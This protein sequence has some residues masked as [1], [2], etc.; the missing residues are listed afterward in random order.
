VIDNVRPTA[1]VVDLVRLQRNFQAIRSEVQASTGILCAVKGDAYGHGAVMCARSLELA[2]ADWFGVALVEEG[3]TLRRAGVSRPIL[4]L[5]GVGPAGAEAAIHHRL[6][7]MISDLG[8]AERINAAAA[9]R[10]EPYGVHLKV[11]TGMGRLGVPLPHWGHFLDRIADLKWLRVDGIASH[12]A[13]SECAPGTGGRVFTEEQGRRFLGAAQ[14]ARQRGLRPALLHLANSG[15]ILE[16]KALHFDLVRPG[17]L[18]YGYSPASRECAL[19]IEPVMRVQ[20][21]VLVVRDLPA[22]VSV[23]YGQSWTTPRPTRIATLPVGYADGYP[24][25]LS[26]RAEVL[27]HGHRAPL[28]GRVCMDLCMVDVTDIPVPVGPGD[29]VVLMGEQGT[30]SIS[31]WDLADWAQTIPYEI[32][33]GFSERVPRVLSTEPNAQ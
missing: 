23:S 30:D 4:C 11:D 2:G 21:Q 1:A 31:A 16:H 8:E 25:A 26:G 7:P 32:L 10:R 9:K 28:R 27:I 14:T 12:L 13:V 33:A 15:A 20:T 18:L 29:E 6:T 19:P 17:L 22:G 24:R 5:G 3:R